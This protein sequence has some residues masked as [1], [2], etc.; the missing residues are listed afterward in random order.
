MG[1]RTISQPGDTS[2]P[3][4]GRLLRA[5]SRSRRRRMLAGAVLRPAAPLLPRKGPPHE[6][7][8]ILGSPR[9]G[10]TLLFETVGHS[11]GLGALPGESHLLWE[12]FHR[13]GPD[14]WSHQARPARL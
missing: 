12:M 14:G 1:A 8:F 2:E 6:P 9:S 3:L 11:P 10:T 5:A 4:S 7:V 13:P